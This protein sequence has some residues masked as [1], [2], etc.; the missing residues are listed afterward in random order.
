MCRMRRAVLSWCLV[1]ALV[2]LAGYDARAQTHAPRVWFC[3][4]PG[5]L[6]YTR[7]FEH[8]EE[9]P[10][11]RRLTS[12]F[13]FYQQHTL[14]P[15][16]R[17]VGPDSYDAFVRAGAFQKL[18]DWH[19]ET[20]IEVASVKEFFCT[21]DGSGMNQSIA[22][23]LRSVRAVEAAGGA[24][25][26]L[27]MDEPF[28]SGRA[29][30]CG[31]PALEPTAD[32][33]AT[34]VSGVRSAFPAVKIGLIEA[35]PFSSADALV[36]VLDLLAARGVLPAFLHIDV[37]LAAIRPAR[38]DFTRDMRR[39]RDTAHARGM[40]FG[41]I[42]WGNNGDAN[43]LYA[44]DAER[45]IESLTGAF[46]SWRD[47]PDDLIVQSWA[48]SSTGLRITPTNLPEKDQYT[49]TNMLWNFYRRL[50]GQSAASTGTAIRR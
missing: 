33:I 31:G 23:T 19:I 13:K 34:Y 43:V 30:V 3:P 35:F 36:T 14:T 28:V 39:L 32:R 29:P 9:W 44:L 4:G 47:M 18:R 45:L 24:V 21:A 16:D 26:Y 40:Q 15:P 38:D 49:H 5:T 20:A 37:D 50:R 10:R 11:A 17:I 48:E 46:T 22:A 42:I 8:P 1:A 12:V 7:L 6:D 2:I 41:I 27:A 25:S